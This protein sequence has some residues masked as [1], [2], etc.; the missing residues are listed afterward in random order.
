MEIKLPPYKAFV[1]GIRDGSITVLRI[2][3]GNITVGD[4][5]TLTVP[6]TDPETIKIGIK[7]IEHPLL[8]TITAK[9]AKEEGYTVPDFCPSK[10][11]CENIESRTDFASLV[12]DQS[13]NTPVSRT[14]EG[15]ER[16]L[17][18][19]VK[20]GCPACLIKKDAKDLFLSYWRTAYHDMENKKI[21]KITFEVITEN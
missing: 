19:R 1:D 16:E 3:T 10:T 2:P 9:E 4:I 7:D 17:Y 12:F 21:A 14:R 11:L 15:I 5:I 6:R 13:G 8:Y 18:E 20:S